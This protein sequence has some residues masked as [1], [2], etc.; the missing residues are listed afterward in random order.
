MAV[1]Y[2][3]TKPKKEKPAKAPKAPK[4]PKAKE[5]KSKGTVILKSNQSG[6]KKSIKKQKKTATKSRSPKV[7]AIVLGVLVVAIAIFVVTYVLPEVKAY[8]EQIE[9]ITILSEPSKTVYLTDEEAD[10]SGLSILVTR[11]NGE[12][13]I[14]GAG[15]CLITGFDSSTTGYQRVIVTYEDC[16]TS[17]SVRVDERPRPTPVLVGITLETLPKTE[18]KVGDRLDTSGGVILCE[19]IDGSVYRVALENSNVS[20][21]SYKNGPG[22][23][24]LTVHYIENTI[25][26]TT[27]YTI[28]VT[29]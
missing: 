1:Q 19:Y 11:K 7:I 13:F 18:Y 28:T 22:T 3:A 14:V 4:T 25:H 23:Y 2:K 16:L 15:K 27:T 10:Y 5:P 21:Y 9:S 8:G 29:E 20:G 12:T 26:V 17:F 24:E 6:S